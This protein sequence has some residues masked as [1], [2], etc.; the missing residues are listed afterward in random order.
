MPKSLAGRNGSNDL[1][2]DSQPAP[3]GPA[4]SVDDRAGIESFWRRVLP[5]H[6]QHIRRRAVC[7]GITCRQ[8]TTRW[9]MDGPRRRLTCAA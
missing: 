3:D 5:F 9:L 4:F 7:T 8:R 1:F 6:T 2:Y